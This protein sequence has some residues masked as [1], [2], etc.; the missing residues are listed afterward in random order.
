MRYASVGTRQEAAA[1]AV[2][3][4]LAHDWV[5]A[6]SGATLQAIA[7]WCREPKTG[8]GMLSELIGVSDTAMQAALS[9]ALQR[10]KQTGAYAM[11]ALGNREELAAA[12][13][14]CG[15]FRR[16]TGLPLI[17][18]KLTARSLPA[19]THRF[20]HWGFFGADHDSF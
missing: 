4:P 15:F 20:D 8:E 6:Y 5:G 9:S 18:R 14:H 12:M 7:V 1:D 10:A 19:N 16:R 13:K 11:H 2:R 3:V 17:L